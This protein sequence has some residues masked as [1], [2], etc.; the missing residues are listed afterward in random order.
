MI[1]ELFQKE[2]RVSFSD[3]VRYALYGPNGYY[4][5]DIT[6]EHKNDFHTSPLISKLFGATI[7]NFFSKIILEKFPTNTV[8]II[9]LGSNDGR[10]ISDILDFFSEHHLDIYERLEVFILE[11]NSSLKKKLINNLQS[12]QDLIVLVDSINT[13][14]SK[15]KKG[16]VFCN[17]LFDALPFN[18]CIVKNGKCFQI[19]LLANQD[20]ISGK[21]EE[22]D[23]N[24]IKFINRFNLKMKEDLFF[25]LPSSEYETIFKDL[26]QQLDE[27]FFLIS[28]YGDKSNY[29]SVSSDP[30]GTARCFYKHQVSRNFY[31]NI[32]SQD[33]THDV[34]FSLLSQIASC[35]GFKEIAFVSQAKFLLDNNILDIYDNYDDSEKL[36]LG[37]GLKELVSPNLLGEKFK[38]LFLESSLC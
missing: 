25:E 6:I 24:L 32:F 30:L 33:I 16:I 28:D 21:E 15:T 31:E 13:I 27:T 22:A 8:S 17:E 5:K 37:Q 4:K 2:D 35:Y 19:N 36:K 7:G 1:K 18:R 34:N 23:K 20:G 14:K 3:F 12:H 9:E 38:F 10:L 11:T 26:S 29:F